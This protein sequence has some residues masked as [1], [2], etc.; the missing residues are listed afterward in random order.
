MENSL[1]K[2]KSRKGFAFGALLILAGAVLVAINLGFIPSYKIL[3]SWQMLLVV[4]GIISL[5][6]RHIFSGLA[7]ISVGAFFF[8]PKLAVAMPE[9]FACINPDTFVSTYWAA[10]LVVAGLLV[11]LAHFFKPKYCKF[12]HHF[13]K[14]FEK[15]F[16]RKISGKHGNFSR[17]SVFGNGEHIILDE[18][19]KGGDV[20]AVFGGITLDLR[21]TH[22]PEGETH[23]EV[24][25][26]FGG[27]VVIVPE[28]WYVDFHLDSVFGG[29][30]DNRV[31]N[32]EIDKSRKLIIE[33]ACV[34]GGGEL[35]N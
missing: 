7:L 32:A 23:L 26:V 6:H 4:I 9:Y 14:K 21:K 29:F 34:F 25:A 28:T 5:F 27:I 18:E 30:Q 11:I 2:Q 35:K 16:E 19:F 8:V 15:N 1:K 3:F 12:E 13:E 24:N 22:L 10:L 20:N 31:S 17:N 33:G